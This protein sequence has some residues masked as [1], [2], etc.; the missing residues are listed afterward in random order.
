M[1]ATID[2][3]SLLSALAAGILVPGLAAAQEIGEPVENLFVCRMAAGPASVTFDAGRAAAGSGGEVVHTYRNIFDG[4]AIRADVAAVRRIVAANPMISSC[5][6]ALWT[7]LPESDAAAYGAKGP[8]GGGGGG[9]GGGKP[10]GGTPTP[11]PAQVTDWGV[12]RIGGPS[13]VSTSGRRAFVVDTG[14]D[15]DHPDLNVD[16]ALSQSFLSARGRGNNS[17]DD[18]NGH[19]SHVAGVIAAID[20][21]IGVVGVAPGA[22]VVSVRVLDKNGGAPDAD[23]AKGLDYI[24]GLIDAGQAGPGDVVNL[25][26]TADPGSSVLDAGVRALNDRGVFVVMAAG[27]SAQDV[28]ASRVSPA[29]NNGEFLY[30]VS[31]F[32]AGDGYSFPSNSG[33]SVDYAEPGEN[34]NSLDKD[35]GYAVKSGTSMAAPHLSGI[36]LAAGS[37]ASDG[38]T[39]PGSGLLGDP[40]G[41][42]DTIG[43]LPGAP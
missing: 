7:G 34:I 24:A 39:S 20:N 27:N 6:Q 8:G 13:S 5:T 2:K 15:L 33:A 41:S 23:V 38:T 37:V 29:Y 14:V 11:T 26:L 21:T 25:S 4:F 32:A 35:G 31:A 10:G 22:T 12:E 40:D 36:L 42:G 16:V 28:D 18:Y 9:G 43:V 3:V 1:A 19:G 17:P 30:S